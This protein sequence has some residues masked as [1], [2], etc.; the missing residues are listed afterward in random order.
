MQPLGSISQTL[1]ILQVQVH[2]CIY[3]ANLLYMLYKSHKTN[4]TV[5]VCLTKDPSPSQRE[6]ERLRSCTVRNI[7]LTKSCLSLHRAQLQ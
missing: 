1:G 3:T 7:G 2:V 5:T 4:C 6:A